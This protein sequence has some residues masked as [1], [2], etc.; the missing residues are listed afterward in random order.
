MSLTIQ[1][2]QEENF[3]MAEEWQVMLDE[4]RAAISEKRNAVKSK[5]TKRVVSDSASR[6][7]KWRAE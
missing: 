5:R 7:A 2:L 6:L 4:K 1:N 3:E